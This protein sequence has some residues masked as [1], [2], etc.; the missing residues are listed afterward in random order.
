MAM[1]EDQRTEYKNIRENF[2]LAQLDNNIHF[3]SKIS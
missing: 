2:C 3:S 1:P